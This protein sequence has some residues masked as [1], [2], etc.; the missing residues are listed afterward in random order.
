MSLLPSF[1]QKIIVDQTAE[2]RDTSLSLYEYG[3]NFNTRQFTGIMV[4]GSE[5]VKVWIWK[6]LMTE[7]FRFPIYSWMYG[8]ELERYIGQVLEQEYID[9]D[10]RLALEDA[11]LINPEITSITNYH[12]SLTN[13]VLSISFT[14]NTIYGAVSILDYK[15]YITKT[16]IERA[17]ERFTTRVSNGTIK[18]EIEN[19]CLVEYTNDDT[20]QLVQFDIDENGALIAS[21]TNDFANAVNLLIDEET[22]TLRAEYNV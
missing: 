8:S 6:C 22:G 3:V 1:V 9:T 10:V 13:D 20:E 11:L 14:A 17:I 7:R 19:S 21:M 16:A 18:F 2:Q 4:N 12:G 5:A 15:I